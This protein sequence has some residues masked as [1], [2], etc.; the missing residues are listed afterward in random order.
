M[1]SPLFSSTTLGGVTVLVSLL[2]LTI[3]C[4][5]KWNYVSS[6]IFSRNISSDPSSKADLKGGSVYFGIP[7]FSYTELEEA[8]NNFDLSKELGDGGFSTVYHGKL[9]DGREVAV[10]HLYENNYKRVSQFMNEIEILTCLCHRNLVSIYGCTSRLSREL[11]LVYEYIPKG[12]VADHIHGL[13]ANDIPLVWAIRM[14]I[15]IET[16]RALAYLH[17]FDIIHRDV[18]TDNILLDN[19]FCVKVADFGLSRLVPNNVTHVSTAP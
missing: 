1:T 9:Q 12:N 13:Q 5:N 15:A 3:W 19:N 11:L 4:N 6:F 17:A 14:N 10:K 8:T 2:I 18:K 16:A 7:V